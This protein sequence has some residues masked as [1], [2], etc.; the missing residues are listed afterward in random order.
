V[1]DA[2]LLNG[3]LER[4]GDVLLA[5]HLRKTL[6]TVFTRQNLVAHVLKP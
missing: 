4:A 3:V 5:N 1:R 6:G 2:L